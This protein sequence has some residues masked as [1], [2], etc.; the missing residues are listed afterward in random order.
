[1]SF[2]LLEHKTHCYF[3]S[4]TLFWG[5]LRAWQ[6]A[7]L[8][9]WKALAADPQVLVE[10]IGE[11]YFS[12]LSRAVQPDTTRDK[13]AHLDKAY[14]KLGI[15]KQLHQSLAKESPTVLGKYAV[16]DSGLATREEVPQLTEF[17]RTHLRKLLTNKPCVF[18][19]ANEYTHMTPMQIPTA[20]RDL[21]ASNPSS[22]LLR[23]LELAM[24]RVFELLNNNDF[25]RSVES[26][27]PFAHGPVQLHNFFAD[28][29][30]PTAMEY[31]QQH[32][33]DNPVL[34]TDYCKKN[35]N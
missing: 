18:N 1:L 30:I 14:K 12:V 16:T 26:V 17:L 11:C 9:L 31:Q 29:T 2:L 8:P 24:T 32:M 4:C 35:P 15:F 5:Q 34:W 7:D 27:A 3:N 6:S 13:V 33:F 19:E 10:E 21:F 22:T 25:D 23:K 28:V 20:R